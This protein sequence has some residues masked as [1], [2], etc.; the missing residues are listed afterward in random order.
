MAE[1]SKTIANYRWLHKSE[2]EKLILKVKN[3]PSLRELEMP[4]KK[5]SI[6]IERKSK[7]CVA[8]ELRSELSP[9]KKSFIWYSP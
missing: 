8:L 3:D 9:L 6:K 2:Y 4:L 5:F 7:K 1:V